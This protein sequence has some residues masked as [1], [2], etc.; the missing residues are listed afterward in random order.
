MACTRGSTVDFELYRCSN[1]DFECYLLNTNFEEAINENKRDLHHWRIISIPKMSLFK[2]S[3]RSSA[4]RDVVKNYLVNVFAS[5][6]LI[7]L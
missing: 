3:F 7:F 1:V 5:V 4:D 6:K 2:L